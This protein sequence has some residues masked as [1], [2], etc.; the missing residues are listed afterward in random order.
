MTEAA[1]SAARFESL[2]ARQKVQVLRLGLFHLCPQDI[3]S[4]SGIYSAD[5]ITAVKSYFINGHKLIKYAFGTTRLPDRQ[6]DF[7][8]HI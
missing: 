8:C 6:T 1:Q 7:T 4:F 3:T 5:F 2:T